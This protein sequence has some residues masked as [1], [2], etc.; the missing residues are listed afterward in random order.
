[1]RSIGIAVAASAALAGLLGTAT[2]AAAASV[3]RTTYLG[4]AAD[5]I[6]RTST[7]SCSSG[8]RHVVNTR[9][10]TYDATQVWLTVTNPPAVV[11]G[12]IQISWMT[13]A[14]SILGLTP[15]FEYTCSSEPPAA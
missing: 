3:T 11:R 5:G 6:T 9:D 1:M 15:K 10:T 13:P 4:T 8:A 2:P 14:G 12:S 7:I